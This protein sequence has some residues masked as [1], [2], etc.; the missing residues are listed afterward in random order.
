MTG[1]RPLLLAQAGFWDWMD[2]VLPQRAAEGARDIDLLYLGLIGVSLFF[3]TIVGVLILRF[4]IKYRAGSKADRSGWV[5]K[6][7]RWEITWTLIP[8]AIGLGLFIWAGW[9][10]YHVT[11][12][13]T[14]SRV[15][16]VAGKQWMWKFQHPD[17]PEEINELHIPAGQAIKLI[18]TSQDV[19]HSLYIPAFRIKQDV[20]PGRYSTVW[21]IPN[22]TGVYHLF[23]AEYCGTEHSRM[24]GEVHVMP[25]ADFE[26]WR[27]AGAPVQ[28]AVEMPGRPAA[29]LVATAAGAFRKFGCIA[30][31]TRRGHV[32][33]PQL[34][35]IFGREVRLRNGERIIADEQY[36]R[37]SILEPNA[38]ITA[39]YPA[40]SL[41]PTYKG[42][43]SEAELAEL[44]EFIR[45]IRD[46]WP[47]E[48]P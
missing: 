7:W 17:G 28:E 2:W 9:V 36:L 3:M 18:M 32:L 38:K 4:G 43:V 41:M 14:D 1:T 23:C 40:P 19:I 25:P 24:R 46:G 34:A 45:A 21:F 13:P 8:T 35:G 6:T 48:T 44:V 12:P 47:E 5:Q 27:S 26:D 15:I 33:A 37:E 30:C 31:H 39:G 16:Y 42:Q 22:R 29:P 10:F 20:V 11:Q